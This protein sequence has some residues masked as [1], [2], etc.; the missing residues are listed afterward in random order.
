ML[1][2][3]QITLEQLNQL[4]MNSMI[5][6][7]SITFTSIGD[8]YLEA[9]MPVCER[10]IQPFGLLHGGASVTLAETVG[11]V[12]S[13]L[14]SEDDEQVVGLEINA[15]HMRAISKGSVKA[16]GKAL[17]LGNKHHIWQIEIFDDNDNLCCISRLT[18]AVLSKKRS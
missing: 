16:I 10:T 18:T 14:C 13:Y 4:S 8:D 15:S 3:R 5:S 7:L 12:A 6:Y 1:W 17:R 9:K 2:R 11:S